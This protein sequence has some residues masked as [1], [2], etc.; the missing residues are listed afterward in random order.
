MGFGL[1]IAMEGLVVMA[2][3]A[4]GL[5][6]RARFAT[7]A[8]A[9]AAWFLVAASAATVPRCYAY[10]KQDFIGARD[11][12]ERSRAANEPVAVVGLAGVAYTQYYAP[13]WIGIESAAQLES[14]DAAH[15]APWLVY[16]LPI[17]VRTYQPAIWRVVERDYRPV[18]IFPGTLQGGGEVYVC[19]RIQGEN[20]V[21]TRRPE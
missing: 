6:G 14:L 16:T 19:R 12:V 15:P 5:L 2:G 20:D 11:F 9:A 7:Q 8:G 3:F 18:K 21:S 1:L 17:E 10:P 4:A 13:R